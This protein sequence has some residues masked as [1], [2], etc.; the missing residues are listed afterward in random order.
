LGL[1]SLRV[2]V[3]WLRSRSLS[4]AIAATGTEELQAGLDVRIPRIKLC[5]P[6]VGV[7]GIRNLVVAGFIL[8]AG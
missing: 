5:G 2:D 1:V 4:T 6:L 7:Q 3:G 8:G